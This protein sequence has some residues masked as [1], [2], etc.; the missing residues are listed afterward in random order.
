MHSSE[1]TDNA[2]GM[3]VAAQFKSKIDRFLKKTGM[4][5]SKF[6]LAA[7]NDANFWFDV[8]HKGRTPNLRTAQKALDYIKAHQ[9]NGSG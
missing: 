8:H 5:P 2:A 4:A 7:V 6:G 1:K 9:K 3:D